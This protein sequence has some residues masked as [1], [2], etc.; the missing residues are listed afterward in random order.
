[1]YLM[2]SVF[3]PF[4]AESQIEGRGAQ[5]EVTLTKS[6]VTQVS[7]PN[8][9]PES[10]ASHES[11][12]TISS[13]F[14]LGSYVPYRYVYLYRGKDAFTKVLHCCTIGGEG[15]FHFRRAAFLA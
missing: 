8:P 2:K 4:H 12:P 5:L 9:T 11:T 1:M 15:S 7:T 6:Y 3:T 14:I 10:A 13:Q